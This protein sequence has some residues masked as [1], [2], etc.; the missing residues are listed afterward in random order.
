MIKNALAIFTIILTFNACSSF[1]SVETLDDIYYQNSS[2]EDSYSYA[3]KYADDDFLWAFMSGILALQNS[4]FDNSII[5]LDNAEIF[6]EE[7]SAENGFSDFGKSL[8]SVLVSNGMF[9]Y[10]PNL[11]EG[12]LLNH[13]KALA[14][15]FMG[16]YASARVEFNR[17]NDRT[18]RTK[19][20][21]S[22]KI[23]RNNAQ[24]E[25]NNAE[26][27]GQINT[28]QNEMLAQADSI[29]AQNYSN[30]AR[31]RSFEG[32][33]NP[34]ISYISGIFFLTQNDFNKANDLLKESYGITQQKEILKDIR[35][36]NS[37]KASRNVKDYYTWL[38]IEDGRIAN[39]T[40]FELD[41]PLFLLGSNALLF[42]VALPN[43]NDGSIFNYQYFA[44]SSTESIDA[45]E[46]NTT[47]NL[48]ANEFD[49]ALPEII[50]TSL[51][52]SSYKAYMQHFL[53]E[54]FGFLGSLGGM[55]FSKITTRADIRSSRILPYRF[56]IL[57]IKNKKNDISVYA[58]DNLIYNFALDLECEDLCLKQDNLVYLR[59][60]PY[61]ILAI[62]HSIGRKNE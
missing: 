1:G 36:L 49:I 61:E 28:S 53:G 31:F 20:F 56:L 4:D 24:I 25:Q 8:A 3:S 48:I 29:I 23:A 55:I 16:D 2:F 40:S 59:I 46:L 41:L 18:R 62:K 27:A 57:R 35:I 19:D 42:S 7:Y 15:M 43:L 26:Y 14:Y 34:I 17:A 5:F 54:K 38:I 45:F 22:D 58:D 10:E 9:A 39:K 11:F 32:Y 21:F 44:N 51:I 30:L 50:I 12:V 52:S 60:L 37:R 33:V 6:F 47:Q 13:Y